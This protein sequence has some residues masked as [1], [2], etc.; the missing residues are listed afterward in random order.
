MVVRRRCRA[1]ARF[2]PAAAAVAGRLREKRAAELALRRALDAVGAGEVADAGGLSVAG[3]LE[4]WLAGVQNT[5]KPTTAKSYGEVLR[6]YV[7]P[8]VGSVQLA[9][10]TPL[11]IR[12]L[13]ADLLDHGGRRGGALSAGTVAIVHRVLRKAL[14]DAVV[15]RLIRAEPALWREGAQSSGCGDSRVDGPTPAASSSTS[16]TTVSRDVGAPPRYWPA[17]RRDRW[18]PLG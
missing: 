5:V 10:L 3:Y 8:R 12:S 17:T 2:G 15:W 13:Y 1:R 6:W 14:N 9:D 16:L 7:M 4:Q 18:A 11:H